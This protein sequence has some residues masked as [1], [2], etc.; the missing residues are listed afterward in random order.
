MATSQNGWPALGTDSSKLYTWNIPT[1]QG[2]VR[3]R[4]RNGSA[5]FLL[6]FWVSWFAAVIQPV[7]GKVLD[8]WG[9]AFRPVRSS[10][11]L[12]N[13]ASGTAVD[14]NAIQ[15]MLGVRGTF[16]PW[17]VRRIHRFLQNRMKGCI[18]WGGDYQRRADE[19]HGEV[20]QTMELVEKRAR[21]LMKYTVRGRKL[22]KANPTQKA[23]ILR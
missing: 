7:I 22:I 17:Q 21:F 3:I 16:K 6:A 9:Y 15:H 20:V 8:D 23:V 19:M 11:D 2:V 13:H 12:S 5:G 10:T 4:M 14:L 1:K 18:R